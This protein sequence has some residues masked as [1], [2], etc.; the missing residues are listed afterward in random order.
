[1]LCWKVT[2]LVSFQ[3]FLQEM[4]PVQCFESPS[5]LARIL[6]HF[7]VKDKLLS[8]SVTGISTSGVAEREMRQ[9]RCG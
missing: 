7:F 8:E 6:K 3:N 2:L 4:S 1:M 9:S 5:C